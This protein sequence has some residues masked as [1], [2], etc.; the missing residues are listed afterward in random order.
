MEIGLEVQTGRKVALQF[1]EFPKYAR[2]NLIDAITQTTDELYEAII[3]AEP[4]KTGKLEASTTKR[5][6]EGENSITGIVAIT[7]DF[8][9]A[10]ALEYGTHRTINMKLTHLFSFILSPPLDIERTLNIEPHSFLRGPEAD[11]AP[12]AFDRMERA[13][14][15][16]IET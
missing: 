1:E 15:R 11:I 2:I 6:V 4:H 5:V 3:G 13:V 8:G 16:A 12:A 14:E 9:K 7:K 10:G